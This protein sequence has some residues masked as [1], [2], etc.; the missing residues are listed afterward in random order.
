VTS[1]AS[2][3]LPRD[4]NIEPRRLL[5][6]DIREIPFSTRGSWLNLSPIVALHTAANEIHLVSHVNG[7]HAVVALT[8]ERQG[9]H[10]AV[11][12]VADP[13]S[14]TWRADD[15]AVVAAFDG[16]RSVRLCGHGLQLRVT[17]AAGELTPFSGVY[18]FVDPADGNHVLTSYETGRR[19]RIRMITGTAHA[20]GV[21]ALGRT[22][23]SV[24]L[25]EA[26]QDWE[27]EIVETTSDP[28][29]HGRTRDFGELVEAS[30]SEFSA[31]ESVLAPWANEDT[32]AAGLAAY[33]LWSATVCAD[34]MITRDAVLMSKHWMDKVW[35]WDHCFNAIAL[36][37]GLP[38]FALDQ[39]LLPFDDQDECGAL[40]DSVAH[41][42]VLYNYVKPPIH[43]WA[44]QRLRAHLLRPLTAAELAVVYDRLARWTR[45]WLHHRR[46]PGHLLPYYQHGNDSGWD[47]AT[48]F[49]SDRVIESPDL[50]AFLTVQ[51][52]VLAGLSRELDLPDMEWTSARDEVLQALI[53]QLWTPEGFTAVGAQTGRPSS[54]T[55]L[56]TLLPLVLGERLP[57][58]MRDVMAERL[59][60]HLTEFGPA[61]EQPSSP[62]YLADG[63]WRGPIWAPSTALIEDGLRVSGFPDLADDVS[64]RFRGLCERSG[65]AE[66][67]DA[68]TGRG[69]RDRAYTWTASV[70]LTL[71][72]AHT[73]RIS[74]PDA[75]RTDDPAGI[76]HAAE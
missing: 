56:L 60:R 28:E 29:T 20:T 66:N 61:T 27:A 30:A 42:E 16:T 24:L 31:F 5:S 8:P 2:T 63:Y 52:D 15:G 70:Y 18:L 36:A 6:F 26:G 11:E 54:T 10:A 22:E 7:M 49:D 1:N 44:L 76:S 40:P 67:F 13:A 19:Y 37:P 32:P 53:D 75:A 25:G 17:E 59:T 14:F 50:A 38:D 46:A 35:S 74:R 41:S 33:T 9:E 48:T 57:T 62:H 34:G 58:H 64:A 47:N 68:L 21:E 65:F 3:G 72:A 51:L 43:G 71:S 73:S 45:F 12:W 69:L 4:E 55:S 39:F 23:R